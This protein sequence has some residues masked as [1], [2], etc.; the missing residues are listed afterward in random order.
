MIP[1]CRCSAGSITSCHLQGDRITV[2]IEASLSIA[3][4][5]LFAVYAL[6]HFLNTVRY[7]ILVLSILVLICIVFFEQYETV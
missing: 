1:S 3:L 4:S 7:E 6:W 5:F 2:G